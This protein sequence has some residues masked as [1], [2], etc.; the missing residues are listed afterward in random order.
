MGI[1]NPRI[2]IV[3]DGGAE[4]E[5]IICAFKNA[6]TNASIRVVGTLAQFRKE[7]AQNPPDIV[8]MDLDLPDG[9]AF[10]ILKPDKNPPPFPILIM[11][12][13]CDVKTAAKALKAGA[14]D[15]VVKSQ[16]AFTTMPLIVTRSLR[17]RDLHRELE[18]NRDILSSIDEAVVIVDR[19]YR[20][21]SANRS[22]CEKAGIPLEEL[23]G[24]HCYEISSD[25]SLPCH[26]LNQN[27]VCKRTFENGE[28][29]LFVRTVTDEDGEQTHL[30][31]KTYAV[32]DESGDIRSVIEIINDITEKS[33]LEA[34]LRHSLKMEAI[35]ILAG[36]IAH[37]FNNVL[38]AVIGYGNL[39]L[40]KM[41]PEDPQR[42][43]VKSILEGA[44]RAA[45][46]TKDLLIFS[47]KHASEKVPIDINETVRHLKGF[48]ERVIGDDVICEFT[49]H[50]EPIV[51][52]ADAHHIEQLL[53]NLAT[54]ARDAMADGGRFVI[55]IKPVTIRKPFVERH[56]YG[57]PGRYALLTVSDSGMG[58]TKVI[59]RKIFD[60]FF[61]TKEAGKGTGLG[62]SVVYGIVKEHDGFINVYSEPGF[63]TS[64]KIYLPII[65]SKTGSVT[66]DGEEK[67]LPSGRETIL[68]AEDDPTARGFTMALLKKLGY[69]VIVAVDGEEAVKSFFEHKDAVDLLL[70]DIVMPKMNGKEAF[71][72]IKPW[73]P[74]LKVIYMSGY[75][76]EIIRKQMQFTGGESL[77]EKPVS[78]FELS[79]EIRRVLNGGRQ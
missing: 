11:S 18:I 24:K 38:S 70:F 50:N 12:P 33:N 78:I 68:L 34:Q 20:I 39:V 17:E 42:E 52:L 64:F 9:S 32:K 36:G 46:L 26:A 29:T 71:N 19:D 79:K 35:G 63:G 31:I 21:T 23:T 54:N 55:G 57:K 16:D 77:V 72:E 6:G 40:M 75:A 5:A 8:L 43:D 28:P 62:M 65:P 10:D 7:V 4:A 74:G 51:V 60:P 59:Q 45:R 22:Y 76:P 49:P 3:D 25:L 69:K 66:E 48:L 61:T 44:N 1:E 56:G 41:G 58:M 67:I 30:A 14:S 2:L 13:R 27:C 47:R 15:Y 37:D 53:M 73:R